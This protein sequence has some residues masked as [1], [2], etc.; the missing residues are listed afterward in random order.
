MTTN[1]PAHKV[2]LGCINATI[3]E[4]VADSGKS[5]YSVTVCRI[6]K[7]GDDW[8]E[9]NSFGRDDLPLVAKV[10]DMAHTWIFEHSKKASGDTSEPSI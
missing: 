10:L 2:K 4:N 8:K 1:Q 7:D 5:Y 9:S 3:W 6:Y